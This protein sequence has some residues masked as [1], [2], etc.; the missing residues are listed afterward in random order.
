VTEGTSLGRKPA[1]VVSL[2]NGQAGISPEMAIRLEK[3]GWSNAD[4]RTAARES[5]V[6][7]SY[8]GNRGTHLASRASWITRRLSIPAARPVRD[9]QIINFLSQVFP[10]RSTDHP[11]YGS[12]TSRGTCCAPSR[13]F[14]SGVAW[15][16]GGFSWYA[17]QACAPVQHQRRFIAF[18][19]R[20]CEQYPVSACALGGIRAEW[21][22]RVE[23]IPTCSRPT[24]YDSSAFGTSTNQT[25]R[26]PGRCPLKLKF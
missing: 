1:Y 20:S 16:T 14:N 10:T 12:T 15:R 25:S 17:L 5:P 3:A 13:S 9:N 23:T 7:A 6:E 18:G 8:V 21:P 4:H 24:H 2:I 11:I 19:A 22:Q 26:T